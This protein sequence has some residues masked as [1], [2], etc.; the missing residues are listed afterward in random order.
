[1]TQSLTTH[2]AACPSAFAASRPVRDGLRQDPRAA[3]TD[4]IPTTLQ[5]FLTWLTARPAPGEAARPRAAW[6]FVAEAL[7][8]I[9]AGLSIGVAGLSVG[10]WLALPLLFLSLTATTSGLGLFQVVVFHHCSHGAVFAERDRNRLVGRLISALLIFKHFDAYRHEHM[11]HHNSRKLLTDEDEFADF[12]LDMCQ[13]EPGVPKRQLWRRVMLNVV[14]SPSFHLKFLGKRI[15]AAWLSPDWLHNLFGVAVWVTTATACVLA[16]Y[17]LMFAVLWV[18]PVTVLLQ[19]A[20]I[21]RI[22]CEHRFPDAALISS[23]NREFTCLV[24]AGVFPGSAPPDVSSVTVSGLLAWTAWWLDMLTVQ[25][26]T[27]VFV[28]VGDAPCH[29]FHHRRPQKHLWT[30]YIH[31]RQ[32]DLDAGCPGFPL[33]YGE[34]WGLINAIDENLASLS[35]TPAGLIR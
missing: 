6:T 1:M 24:T 35:R 8:W 16:G 32:E 5:P 23:R 28:L 27:R 3:M 2:T 13:L 26:F 9:A 29:D 7:L 20:T 12:V 14:L 19:I 21:G 4:R 31:A 15:L 30:N 18:L 22:L 25:L 34:S 17:T 11:L 10:L 33:N